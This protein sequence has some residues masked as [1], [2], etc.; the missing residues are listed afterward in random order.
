MGFEN[1][2]NN[3][4]EQE[5]V[6]RTRDARLRLLAKSSVMS[7]PINMIIALVLSVCLFGVVDGALHGFWLAAVFAIS[8][9]RMAIMRPAHRSDTAPSRQ[10]MQAYLMLSVVM[11]ALW[12]MT[13]FMLNPDAPPH[14]LSA[15][16]LMIA[17]MTA[18][19]ALSSAAKPKAV[20]AYNIPAILLPAA[21]FVMEGTTS[22]LLFAG[23]LVIFLVMSCR[24]L[25]A[26]SSHLDEAVRAN[27][28]LEETRRQTEVQAAAMT[29]LAEHNDQAARRAEEQS[30]ANAAVL[31]NMSH[32]L[33]TP[34]NGVLGMAQ[35]LQ[36]TGLEG[37][38]A[39]LAER[40]R[41][42]AEQLNELLTDVLDVARIEAG[43][44]ELALDDVTADELAD[45]L[46]AHAGPA[47]RER[48]LE[49][50]IERTGETGRAIRA[51][52]KRL[53]QIASIF[54]NNAICFTKEGSVTARFH[55]DVNEADQAIMRVE[56]IDTGDGVP[57][58]ARAHLFDALAEQTMDKNIREAGTGLGLHLAKRLATLMGG[59][60]GYEPAGKGSKFWFEVHV[61]ASRRE[62]KYADGEQL[63]IANRRLRMLL[64]EAE[65]VRRS[66]LLGY[67]KSF[68]CV[69]SCTG[70]KAELTE[71]LNA[72][73]YDAVILGAKLEDGSADEAVAEIRS[74]ASTA[75][76][77]PVVRLMPELEEP[78]VAGA[79]ETLVRTP[80]SSESLMEG[81]RQALACDVTAS[82]NLRRYG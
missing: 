67:L 81:L 19:S 22:G 26:Y 13:P 6:A 54:V 56:I 31:A 29:R 46:A 57:E 55:T 53:H 14:A 61:R 71:A 72:A 9:A 60:A 68:N 80:V 45:R 12:G 62:D 79:S 51:D 47:A 39:H 16:L 25:R 50:N 40:L 5:V 7:G 66:V 3:A 65:A 17:G 43:R 78:V 1:T 70:S 48:G 49:F 37:E 28:D 36:E 42:S 59:T 63:T 34:L 52:A 32:E 10:V 64:C 4:R 23:V 20:M 2:R 82:V 41:Q 18:G 11:G 27:I 21:Y 69:V 77:T 38:K 75:A 58:S 44:I 30:R 8:G 15:S 24:L 33:R 76:M 74:L 73:A 35:L